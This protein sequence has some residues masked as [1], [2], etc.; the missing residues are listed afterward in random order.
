METFTFCPRIDPVGKVTQ[1]SIV[2]QFG[3][4]Y[5]QRAADGI[6]GKSESWPLEF[7]GGGDYIRPIRDFLDR[8]AGWKSFLWTPPM[9]QEQHFVTPEGYSLRA[10]GGDAYSLSVTFVQNNRLV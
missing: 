3:D 10:M 4:G 2:A 9:G 1:R 7:V 6:N 5:A 8:H